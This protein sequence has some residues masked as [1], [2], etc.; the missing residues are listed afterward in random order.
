[1]KKDAAVLTIAE[2]DAQA[3]GQ[4]L[5]LTKAA[6]N[7]KFVGGSKAGMLLI[8]STI[9]NIELI[10]QYVNSAFDAAMLIVHVTYGD[11]AKLRISIKKYG[12]WELQ[13]NQKEHLSMIEILMV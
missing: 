5:L 1:M 4:L 8:P 13:K 6:K 9:E 2:N 3:Y 11:Y 10:K 12:W 7:I